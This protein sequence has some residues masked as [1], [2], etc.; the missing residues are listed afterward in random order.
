[1]SC[2]QFVSKNNQGFEQRPMNTGRPP[3]GGWAHVEQEDR[4]SELRPVYVPKLYALSKGKAQSI[5]I[6]PV[7]ARQTYEPYCPRP[8]SCKDPSPGN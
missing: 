2:L 3:R 6:R 5:D 1:M 4:S 7:S 8:S